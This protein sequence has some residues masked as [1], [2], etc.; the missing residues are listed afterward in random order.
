MS[1]GDKLEPTLKLTFSVSAALPMVRHTQ[2]MT[3]HYEFVPVFLSEGRTV[4]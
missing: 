1:R 4:L 3:L 2:Q